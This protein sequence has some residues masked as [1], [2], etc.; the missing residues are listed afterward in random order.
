MTNSRQTTLGPDQPSPFA[1]NR[2]VR[3][4]MLSA[5]TLGAW[6]VCHTR[7]FL[8]RVL[9]KLGLDT[10]TAA[11]RA[12]AAAH[13]QVQG[14]I[15]A[16]A[17]PTTD[18]IPQALAKRS[19]L[20]QNEVHLVDER[21]RLHGFA[22]I[23]YTRNGIL[24]I[25]ELKNSRPPGGIDPVWRAPVRTEH[26]VQIQTYGAIAHA[27]YGQTPRLYVSYM[28]GGSKRAALGELESSRDPAAALQQFERTSV[29]L[30]STLL[31]RSMILNEARSFFR[32]EKEL[33][34]PRP[35]HASPQVCHFCNVKAFCSQR[36]DRP[37]E[38]AP[39]D[40]QAL[41]DDAA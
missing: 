27:V 1:N 14:A 31:H 29:H 38:F 7:P 40:G 28:A 24:H 23:V 5:T 39:L 15:E 25:L 35:S 37:G 12:G 11:M 9:E 8:Q 19:F 22:D 20:V 10:S 26:G 17:E 41:G 36:L 21:R 4:P 6:W 30:S 34:V 13:A 16:V 33:H 3:K 2:V 18:T 32:A